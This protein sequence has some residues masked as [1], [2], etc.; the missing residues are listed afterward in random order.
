LFFD[1]QYEL[2]LAFNALIEVGKNKY[3]VIERLF[4]FLEL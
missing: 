1:L 3:K 4:Y 2:K